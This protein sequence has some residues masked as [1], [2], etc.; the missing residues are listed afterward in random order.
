[1]AAGTSSWSFI[2][3]SSPLKQSD[4]SSSFDT[5]VSFPPNEQTPLSELPR[6]GESHAVTARLIPDPPINASEIKVVPSRGFDFRAALIQQRLHQTLICPGCFVQLGGDFHFKVLEALPK[7]LNQ[8]GT[9]PSVY[10]IVASTNIIVA[11]VSDESSQPV[12]PEQSATEINQPQISSKK[13][14]KT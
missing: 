11:G 8:K 5:R 3:I 14:G 2:C 9:N 12:L 13:K 7:Q 6:L 4:S 10:R 1:M